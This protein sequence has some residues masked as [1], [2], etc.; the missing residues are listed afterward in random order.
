MSLYAAA[1]DHAAT[2]N[3]AEARKIYEEILLNNPQDQR[4][5]RMMYRKTGSTYT[6]QWAF[7][8]AVPFFEKAD[9]LYD[10]KTEMDEADWQEWMELQIDYCYALHTTHRFDRFKQVAAALKPVIDSR[11]GNVQKIRYFKV[12]YNDMLRRWRWFM[13]P[14]EA[15]THCQLIINLAKAEGDVGTEIWAW[16][17]LGFTHLFRQET[18]ATRQACHK[19]LELLESFQSDEGISMAYSYI[20]VSYRKDRDMEGVAT[21]A[22]KAIDHARQNGNETSL[23]LNLALVG[24]LALKNGELEEAERIFVETLEFFHA[25]RHPFLPVCLLPLISISLQKNDVPKAAEYAF[26]LLHP[27]V[28]QLPEDITQLLA[29]GI[30]N[31]GENDLEG[32]ARHFSAAIELA[33]KQGYL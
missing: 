10:L 31:W 24:W 26:M 7:E 19:A 28:Q 18:A 5:S 3:Y 29:K 27:E 32:A 9:A 6:A 14:E 33:D 15:L 22:A 23:K 8:E 11:A 13:L 2:G 30:D 1:D 20:A 16:N 4:L 21:W 12:I 17:I 25:F